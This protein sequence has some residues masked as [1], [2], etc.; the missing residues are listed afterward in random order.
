VK[1]LK[2]GVLVIVLIAALGGGYLIGIQRPGGHD[3]QAEQAAL[4]KGQAAGTEKKQ[5]YTCGMHPFVIKDEPGLCPICGMA[6]TP[7]KP[8]GNGQQTQAAKVV[9]QWRSPMDPTYVRDAPGKD[10]MGHDLVPVTAGDTGK[11]E[12]S[13]DPVTAQNM[14]VRTESVARRKLV[15]SIRTVGLMTYEEGRQF[16][17]NSK[18]EGW[19]EKLFVNQEGQMVEKGQPLMQIYSP[20]LVAAQQEFL[21][22][23]QN[24][25]KLAGNP[26]AEIAESSGRLLEAARTRLKYWDISPGQ[27][28]AIE[29]SGK[30]TKTLTLYSPHSGVVTGKKAVAG[31]RIM[32]GEEL[33]QVSDISNIWINADIFEYELPWVKVGQT[34]RIEL[35][36][37]AGKAFEGRI[38]YIYPYL[39]NESRTARARIEL[40]NPGLELKPDMYANV[41]IDTGTVDGALAI[42]A[43]AILSSGKGQTVFVARSG[44]KYEPRPVKTGVVDDNGYVQILSGL[45]EGESV[46]VSAQFML[47]SESTLREAM[48]KM[49]EPAGTAMD[50]Q[51]A[52]KPEKKD[53]ATSSPAKG[54]KKDLDDL[55]K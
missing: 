13:I 51:A 39:N 28:N 7:V 15:K 27:I 43:N 30:I 46:V 25:R 6:L 37:A 18:I 26:V 33:L 29:R 47:D 44:G 4:A 2:A 40:A 12:I 23:L 14:G 16:S 54:G 32:A 55:F 42:P 35:P 38:T 17:I 9:T 3:H 45:S 21:L 8:G 24:S 34:A 11:G 22:A 5:Q 36:F 19:I 10:Y 41:R 52:A 31:M 1:V 53:S 49:T 20:D 50:H 48:Q